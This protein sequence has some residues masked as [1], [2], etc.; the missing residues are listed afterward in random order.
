MKSKIITIFSL[1][2]LLTST[3]S[4]AD[5]FVSDVSKRGTTAAPFLSIGQG[6]RALAMGGAFVAVAD[7]QSAMYWN[8]AG[9]ADLQGNRVM[10]DYTQWIAD[11]K[12]NY[13]GTT[14][15]L[16]SIGTV[17]LN[18]TSSSI[19]DMN[20]TT[21]ETPDGTGE[22]F[23]VKD[24]AFGVTYALKLTD[25]FAIGF[26]P[27]LIYQKIWKMSASAIA[28]DMG[29][30]YV[31]P[32]KGITLG[33]SISN[34]GS[35]MQMGGA[36]TPVLYDPDPLT[37]GNNGRI[38]ADIRTEQWTL[39]LN[40]RVGVAYDVFQSEGS[41]LLLAIDA[42]HPSDDYESV[43]VGGEY[44]FNDFVF[45]R[46]GYKSLFLKDTEERFTLGFGIK[47]ALIGSTAITIDYAYQD[48][49]RLKNVQKF[50]VGVL[51]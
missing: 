49:T 45:L 48:F 15:N 34:F 50:T 25:R 7:D 43:D 32:F 23:G 22:T 5:G 13:L 4:A 38:P 42:T 26:N 44:V 36:S 33:M 27:K 35:K 37:T 9:I 19:P 6:A 20:L 31:T 14:I 3:L 41:R 29:V 51:F 11:I 2:G 8:P 47:Q 46:G 28:I 18:F 21:V 12:Y 1:L 10:F 30:K 17:G 16:G 39:P 40:F 24:V